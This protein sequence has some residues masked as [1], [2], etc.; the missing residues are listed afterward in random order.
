MGESHDCFLISLLQLSTDVFLLI[1]C[2]IKFEREDIK[3]V[4]I[5]LT[6]LKIKED[7]YLMFELLKGFKMT[8]LPDS[9]KKKKST[10]DLHET[11]V[12]SPVTKEKN[13]IMQLI[14]RKNLRS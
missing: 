12:K 6:P 9:L 2:E 7:R 14:K 4:E 3:K 5:K 1:Y 10:E 13:I 8:S 11:S